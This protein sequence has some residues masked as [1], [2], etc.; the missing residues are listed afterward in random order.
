MLPRKYIL[1]LVAIWSCTSLHAEEDLHDYRYYKLFEDTF[2]LDREAEAADSLALVA[3]QTPV[4][5]PDT[6]IF[7][8]NFSFAGT[9]RRGAAHFRR[10]TRLAGIEVSGL[11]RTEA[12]RLQLGGG[13]DDGIQIYGTGAGSP[14]GNDRYRFDT[15]T[16]RRTS[17]AANLSTRDYLAGVSATAA[18]NLGHGWSIAAD[19][20]LRT[21]R[22]MHVEGVFTNALSLNAVATKRIDSLHTVSMA[23]L[24]EP[25]ERGTR[26]ASVEEAFSL[27]GNRL[28][29]PAWGMQ[30]GK[31]RNDNVRRNMAPTLVASWSGRLS[32]RTSLMLS[33]GA[34][35]GTSRYSSLE[36]FDAQTPAPDNYRYMPSYFSDGIEDDVAA[37][38]RD[39]NLRYTQ[40]DFDELVTRNRMAGGRSVYAISDR[41]ERITRLALCA[42]GTTTL[43]KRFSL[44]YGVELK[45]DRSRRYKQLRD[46]LGSDYLVDIDY[47]LVDDDTFGNALQNDLEN[48]DRTVSRGGRYGYDYALTQRSLT[49]MAQLRYTA[50]RLHAEVAVEVGSADT[51]RHGYYRK[52]LFK[53]SSLGRS[54][55]ISMM[56]WRVRA[57]AAYELSP[58]HR[59]ELAAT[60]AAE[61]PE[62]ENLFLQADYN[63]RTTD[64]PALR[65]SLAAEFNYILNVNK[66]RLRA[67]LFASLVRDDAQVLHRYDDIAGKYA[68]IVVER[69][70]ELRF[71]FEGEVDV[72]WTEHLRSG[73]AVGV[74]R[75]TY[76]GNPLVSIY[77]DNDNSRIADRV[78][79]H[80]GDYALGSAPQ[81]TAAATLSYF[82]RG[83][84]ANLAANYAGLRHVT[85]DFL[86]RTERVAYMATSPEM[87]DRM[88]AQERLRD[89]FT[90]DASLSKTLY[91]SRYDRHIYRRPGAPRFLDRYPRSRITLFLSVRNLLGSR[92]TVQSAYESS[93]LV[94]SRIA[95]GYNYSPQATRYLYAYPRTLYFSVRFTF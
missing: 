73:L 43:S 14:F 36:W 42:R 31:V 25:S 49:A 50:S 32:G 68:D 9:R 90:L 84:G 4:L 11:S 3:A 24:F 89:A 18:A 17:V 78:E 20:A 29:N 82:N 85:P 48:P 59:F 41:V 16:N 65:K 35:A 51:R 67:T 7:D 56:P 44:G 83:W 80:I 5:R 95:D 34:T 28:Y 21:G 61:M 76:A 45:F 30:N 10:T 47:F 53:N 33:A 52:E 13:S 26:R 79:S 94:R 8:Y 37:A 63:N 1:L 12:A 81:I 93:R 6:R 39:N 72:R 92:N 86:R 15:L 58:R 77:S 2:A 40:I 75:Y 38:W 74:G 57:A 19:F 70:G 91:L 71:G 22:D 62:V 60:A 46:M 54:R 69:I 23:L 87:F 66:V 88:T 27:T 55:T 64:S